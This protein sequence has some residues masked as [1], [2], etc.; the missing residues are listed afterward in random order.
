LAFAG[1]EFELE[2]PQKDGATLRS[3]LNAVWRQNGR[4]PQQLEELTSVQCPDVLR[5]MWN[6][7]LRI[8]KKRKSN[9]FGPEYLSDEQIETWFRLRGR[10][11]HPWQL[12]LLDKL[13]EVFMKHYAKRQDKGN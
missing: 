5:P 1:N 7:F 2:T 6:I 9:G 12:E 10:K 13:D 8:A 11:L 4:K 3:V